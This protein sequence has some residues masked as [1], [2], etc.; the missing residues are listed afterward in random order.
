MDTHLTWR[1]KEL[2][3]HN[4]VRSSRSKEIPIQ[5]LLRV[6]EWTEETRKQAHLLDLAIAGEVKMRW[7]DERDHPVYEDV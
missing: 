6:L 1:E 5:H 4:L 2:L 3:M 7:D